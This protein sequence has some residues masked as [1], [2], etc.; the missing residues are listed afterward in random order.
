VGGQFGVKRDGAT[1]VDEVAEAVAQWPRFATEAG[2]PK[3]VA[4]EITR[5]HRIA[6]GKG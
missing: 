2:V 3:G 1:V 5:A 4:D 6:L